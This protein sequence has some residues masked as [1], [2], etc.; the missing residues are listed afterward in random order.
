MAKAPTQSGEKNTRS[1]VMRLLKTE[2]PMTSAQLADQL[3]VTAMAVRFVVVRYNLLPIS[4]E[5]V[6]RR[7]VAI[8]VGYQLDGALLFPS[9]RLVIGVNE[10]VRIEETTSAH[11]SHRG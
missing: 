5:A 8:T 1:S 6:L 10:N 2:G 7:S 3:G 11:E 4:E 9:G